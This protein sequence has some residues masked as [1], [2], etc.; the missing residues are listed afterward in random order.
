MRKIIVLLCLSLSAMGQHESIRMMY[1]FM[2]MAINPAVAG[3]QGVATITGIYRKKPLFQAGITN[4]A[5]SQQYFNFDMPVQQEKGGIG[6][7]AYNT[8]Q[9]YALPSGGISANL[10]ISVVGAKAFEWGRGKRIRLGVQLGLNQYPIIGKSGS[11]VL[12]AHYGYGLLY[13][14]GD[15]QVG[16]SAPANSFEASYGSVNRPYYLSSQYLWH[17]DQHTLK[18][19][20]VI[21]K[22]EKDV[23]TDFYAVFWFKEKLGAGIWY[24]KTGSELG[25]TALLG[26]LEVALGKNFRVG[27]GYDFL[28]EST[29]FFPAGFGSGGS[30]E[31]AGFHQIFMRY[32]VDLGNGKIAQFR[33]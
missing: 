6:F 17:I 15:F 13:E 23:S 25:S 26:S 10:G 27:Y 9:S 32:E 14:Q 12:G 5:S 8:D 4:T 18:L 11:S 30:T 33:P 19:G 28:G 29:V 16:L 31:R 21:R 2:P 24:Q 3:H 1:P 7:L 22:V 20:S